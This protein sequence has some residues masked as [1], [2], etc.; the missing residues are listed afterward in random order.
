MSQTPE[1][2][3]KTRQD[4]VANATALKMRDMIHTPRQAVEAL[5]ACVMLV[6]ALVGGLGMFGAMLSGSDLDWLWAGIGLAAMPFLI[7]GCL[8]WFR[9]IAD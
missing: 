6:V 8:Y 9:E 2:S 4:L 3:R 1:T 7:G 5:L